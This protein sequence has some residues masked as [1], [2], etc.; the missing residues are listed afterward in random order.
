MDLQGQAW[1]TFAEFLPDLPHDLPELP[2]SQ[3]QTEA[4]AESVHSTRTQVIDS[5]ECGGIFNR[6]PSVYAQHGSTNKLLHGV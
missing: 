2:Q 5:S 1:G 3:T 6:H 4:I